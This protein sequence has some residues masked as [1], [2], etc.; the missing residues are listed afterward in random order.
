MSRLTHRWIQIRSMQTQCCLRPSEFVSHT[1]TSLLPCPSPCPS[2]LNEKTLPVWPETASLCMT[3]S[4]SCRQ[5]LRRSTTTGRFAHIIAREAHLSLVGS[6]MA[7]T[8][9]RDV[10]VTLHRDAARV[11]NWPII[12]ISTTQKILLFII[13]W[14]KNVWSIQKRY[15]ALSFS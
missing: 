5:P 13:F 11:Q 10:S 3:W 15:V 12:E 14:K 9:K 6:L 7:Q 2:D 8:Q 4:G 1:H